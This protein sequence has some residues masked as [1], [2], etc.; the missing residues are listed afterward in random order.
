MKKNNSTNDMGMIDLIPLLKQKR[1]KEHFSSA[2][3][4][5]KKGMLFDA[6]REW[7][8]AVSINRDDVQ[9]NLYLALAYY[10]TG[11]LKKAK[12]HMEYVLQERPFDIE[13]L[14]YM[15]MIYFELKDYDRALKYFEKIL[16]MKPDD[17]EIL[18]IVSEAYSAMEMIQ[19]ASDIADKA[20]RLYPR[21]PDV[22]IRKA[23]ILESYGDFHAAV[24]LL[25][26]SLAYNPYHGQTHGVL[27]T[28]YFEHEWL[29]FAINSLRKAVLYLAEPY[30]AKVK[31]SAAL[32][33]RGKNEEATFLLKS[34]LEQSPDC[35]SASLLLINNYIV[36]DQ[37]DEAERMISELMDK[38]KIKTSHV[39]AMLGIIYYKRADS[40]NNI[41]MYKKASAFF[42]KALKKDPKSVALKINLARSLLYSGYP[43][44]ALS[45]VEAFIEQHPAHP[46]LY[47]LLGDIYQAI[48]LSK[49]AQESRK[50]AEY[51]GDSQE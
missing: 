28:F 6:I 23:V 45:N 51:L 16:S 50:L 33:C 38:Y 39:Y 12:S 43:D 46:Q 11:D 30:D 18:L 41:K 31:L 40:G 20:I 34:L 21:D 1:L 48:G 26:E 15:G 37:L 3:A 36:E 29:D 5:Q 47:F 13:I 42:K 44:T 17:R 22:I 35:I 14:G 25:R 8:N 4:F 49:Y 10:E 19:E 27:G 32:Y 24:S 2:V 7:Q 9:A